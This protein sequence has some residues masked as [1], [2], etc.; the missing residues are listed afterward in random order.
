[1]AGDKKTIII[2]IDTDIDR[3]GN[4]ERIAGVMAPGA[5]IL[6]CQ[7]PRTIEGGDGEDAYSFTALSIKAGLADSTDTVFLSV[8]INDME[9]AELEHERISALIDKAK[10]RLVN[11]EGLEVQAR[12]GRNAFGQSY[13]WRVAIGATG[14]EPDQVSDEYQ[15]NG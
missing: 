4:P 2:N 5:C 12:A 10:P 8:P 7:P 13:R 9:H 11:L 1:M 14:V 3:F 6:E 15:F